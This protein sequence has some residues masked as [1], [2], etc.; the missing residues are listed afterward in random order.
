VRKERM[1]FVADVQCEESLKYILL[2][3]F[4]HEIE[5]KMNIV[6]NLIGI[7]MTYLES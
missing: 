4:I 7:A 3:M 5:T 2:T 1:S 6:A